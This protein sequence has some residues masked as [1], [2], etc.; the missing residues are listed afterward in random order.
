MHIQLKTNMMHNLV[1]CPL[2]IIYFK[3]RCSHQMISRGHNI[4]SS[5]LFSLFT[6]LGIT[7]F[8]TLSIGLYANYVCPSYREAFKDSKKSWKSLA[9]KS[10]NW[11]VLGLIGSVRWC[12]R[13]SPQG[14]RL[15][16]LAAWNTEPC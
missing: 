14:T 11:A 16:L 9:Q 12:T 6:L 1:I 7:V 2:F 5:S 15:G 8:H 13:P 10:Q 4:L 3:M